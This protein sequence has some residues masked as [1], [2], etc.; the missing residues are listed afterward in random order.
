MNLWIKWSAQA[1]K[2]AIISSLTDL[3][4]RAFMIILEVSKEMRKGG[5][6][7]DRRHLQIIL[8]PRYSRGIPRLITEGL[9]EES[10]SGLISVSKWFRWQ[11]DPTSAERQQ[12]SRAG[13]GAE[14]RFGHALEKSREER[15]KS[16][17]LTKANGPEQIGD[18]L[19]RRIGK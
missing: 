3:Q 2:D 17:T 15:E 8:G 7:R 11:V 14:S 12:R 5:E 1:H 10:Q 4:F 13:K 19:A 6:F 9:L 16:Q 18:Y